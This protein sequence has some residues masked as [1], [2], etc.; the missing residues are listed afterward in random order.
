M[1]AES[2]AVTVRVVGRQ[3]GSFYEPHYVYQLECHV[4]AV[5]AADVHWF[6]VPCTTLGC[7]SSDPQ[8]Q[9]Y[10]RWPSPRSTEV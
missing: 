5:P 3:T 2:P 9:P 10:Q 6:I 8:W 7:V 4:S 1:V